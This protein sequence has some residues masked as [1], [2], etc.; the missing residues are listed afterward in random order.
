MRVISSIRPHSL[1]AITTSSTRMAPENASCMPAITLPSVDWA[2]RPAMIDTTPADASR[3]APAVWAAGKSSRD[4]ASATMT[5]A[6]TAT[7]RRIRACVRTRRATRLSATSV[8]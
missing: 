4:A 1:S 5:I 3:D 8:R 6:T 7:R 2:A